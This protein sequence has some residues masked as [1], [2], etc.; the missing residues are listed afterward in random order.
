MNRRESRNILI[1][2]LI[3]AAIAVTG[4]IVYSNTDFRGTGFSKKVDAKWKLD[5]TNLSICTLSDQ[6][7]DARCQAIVGTAENVYEETSLDEND[8]LRANFTAR[9]Y[10]SEDSITYKVTVKNNGL[11]KAKLTSIR[12]DKDY[13]NP[14]IFTYNN[15]NE[16][17][18]L[19][20]GQSKTFY[21]MASYVGDTPSNVYTYDNAI[22]LTFAL[23]E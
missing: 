5:L 13:N 10:K 23:A 22:N 20:P 17:E 16:G 12:F 6:I 4:S 19:A 11:L 14:V 8:S 7:R 1:I 9:L 3:V 2:T 18:V 15:I 21:V